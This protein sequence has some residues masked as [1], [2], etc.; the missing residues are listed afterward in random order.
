M[1]FLDGLADKI[2]AEIQA[3]LEAVA[4]DLGEHD[5]HCSRLHEQG[6]PRLRALSGVA[7]CWRG[8]PLTPWSLGGLNPSISA[9]GTPQDTFSCLVG[10]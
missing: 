3:V 9:E 10:W 8:C 6:A 1:Q 2:V 7:S 5:C 4:A